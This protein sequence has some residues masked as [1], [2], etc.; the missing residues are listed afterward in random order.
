[1][2]RIIS[3]NQDINIQ[4]VDEGTWLSLKAAKRSTFYSCG[5]LAILKSN[6]NG[7]RYAAHY[8]TIECIHDGAI[9]SAD[10]IRLKMLVHD[11]AINSGE[12]EASIEEISDD[13]SFISDVLLTRKSDGKKLAVEIQLSKQAP[14]EYR[15]R[16]QKYYDAGIACLWVVKHQIGETLADIPVFNIRK[17]ETFYPADPKFIGSS[18]ETAIN[19]ALT[20]NKN[21]KISH[22]FECAECG[23]VE[24]KDGDFIN[25]FIYCIKCKNESMFLVSRD[26]K[27]VEKDI[28]DTSRNKNFS[29]IFSKTVVPVLIDDK[30]RSKEE[31]LKNSAKVRDQNRIKSERA[32][33]TAQLQGGKKPLSE[34]KHTM[35]LGSLS[36]NMPIKHNG[37]EIMKNGGTAQEAGDHARTLGFKHF[38]DYIPGSK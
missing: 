38:R 5:H 20:D 3:D 9:E 29:N 19:S 13:R 26:V 37:A 32:K 33:R 31:A 14:E 27:S 1:M 7:T 30:Y 18:L 22:V 25:H 36:N 10:H 21:F 4:N 28:C 35:P 11:V 8:P 23:V 24:S 12:W 2:L 16:Q 6:F 15:R 17:T 34:G